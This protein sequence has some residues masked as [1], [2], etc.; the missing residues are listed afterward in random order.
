M[1]SVGPFLRS[2]VGRWVRAFGDA[3]LRSGILETLESIGESNADETA[4][5]RHERAL[6]PPNPRL[7]ALDPNAEK[8]VAK[9][10]STGGVVFGDFFRDPAGGHF[11]L[12]VA[13][14]SW[15]TRV[16]RPP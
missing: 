10:V 6:L 16:A 1:L 14:R 4:P 15:A 12:D 11:H 5:C 2:A 8:L 9:A 13:R 7:T 3:S